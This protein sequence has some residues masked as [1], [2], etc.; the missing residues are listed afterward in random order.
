MSVQVFYMDRKGAGCMR[1]FVKE[2]ELERFV[3][4]LRREADITLDGKKIGE[5]YRLDESHDEWPRRKW[6]WSFE[7]ITEDQYGDVKLRCCDPQGGG[8]RTCFLP[9]KH[10]GPHIFQCDRP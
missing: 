1:T 9:Y 3:S 4:T 10:K 2:G 5:V 8:G 6:G 7:R